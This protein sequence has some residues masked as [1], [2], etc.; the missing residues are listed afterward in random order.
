MVDREE[1]FPDNSHRARENGDKPA[2]IAPVRQR[3]F[4]KVV[5]GKAVQRKK[6]L[7][8]RFSETFFDGAR[9]EDVVEYVIK[10]IVVPAAKDLITDS[11]QM[12][13][14]RTF[15]GDRLPPPRHRRG[16]KS[17][18]YDDGPYTPYG[19]TS[20]ESARRREDPRERSAHRPRTMHDWEDVVV[21]SRA[22]AEAVLDKMYEALEQYDQ[23]TVLDLYD[24]CEMD[25]DF[26]QETWGWTDLGR[27]HVG[28]LRGGQYVIELP[29]PIELRHN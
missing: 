9:I 20:R 16:G 22:E 1:K 19:R 3:K 18:R 12:G 6:S 21:N 24:M 13:L 27:A 29:P 7:V 23:V 14:H 5:T 4:D 17:S 11:V 2:D 28:R 26:T 15:H 8:K 25:S 10:D